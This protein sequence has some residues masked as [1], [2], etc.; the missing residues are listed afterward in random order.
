MN[1]SSI[2]DPYS[3]YKEESGTFPI[4]YLSNTVVFSPE[5]NKYRVL[6][7]QFDIKSRANGSASRLTYAAY[8]F[9]NDI[10][11]FFGFPEDFL[12]SDN[13][14]ANEIGMLLATLIKSTTDN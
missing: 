4:G 5:G 13:E 3:K 6:I 11:Y 9:E 2:G 1:K 10:L 14:K 7:Y 12:K 8:A